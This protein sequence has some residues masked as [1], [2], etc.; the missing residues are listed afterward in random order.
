MHYTSIRIS[1]V[2]RELIAFDA[3]LGWWWGHKHDLPQS[4]LL[5]CTTIITSR[6]QFIQ[7]RFLF[8]IIWIHLIVSQAFL[9]LEKKKLAHDHSPGGDSGLN[10]SKICVRL[11]IWQSKPSYFIAN[12]HANSNVVLIGTNSRSRLSGQFIMK[13]S[14]MSTIIWI[15]S[16][17]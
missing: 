10:I 6:G 16:W 13:F 11:F 9:R 17:R 12:S 7:M 3:G 5:F 14:C 8:A 2:L 1:T 4:Q 15:H